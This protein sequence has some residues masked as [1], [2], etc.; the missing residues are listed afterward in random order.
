MFGV[1][2][3]LQELQY[4]YYIVGRGLKNWGGLDIMRKMKYR[5]IVE[6]DFRN[7]PKEHE[8]S[9]AILIANN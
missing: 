6:T 4:F 8:L 2:Y 3:A 1:C 5:V 9:A 7:R